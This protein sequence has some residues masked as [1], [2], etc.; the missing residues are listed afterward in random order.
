MVAFGRF[1]TSGSPVVRRHDRRR[2]DYP[3]GVREGLGWFALLARWIWR[4]P[5]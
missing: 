1:V 4:Y 2:A 3:D 5:T